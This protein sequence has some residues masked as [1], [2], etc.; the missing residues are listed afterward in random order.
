MNPTE[1]NFHPQQSFQHTLKEIAV[2]REDPCE[3]VRELISNA[4][5]AKATE[6]LVLPFLQRK[7]LIFFDNGVGLSERP[8]DL[9][10]GVVPY[11]AFF[12][13]GKTT[14]VKGSG[15]GYKCQGSKL[16][17][18]S[19]RVTIITRCAWEST[20]RFKLI[21]NPKQTLNESYD[22][23]AELV[24]EPWRILE[25]RIITEPDSRSVALLSNLS[26]SFFEEKFKSGTLIIVDGFDVQ[27]Y[28]KYF[29]VGSTDLS[30]LY[31][32]IRFLTA[33]GDARKFLDVN[34]GFTSVDANSVKSNL[35]SEPA[36]LQV[37]M[38][39]TSDAWV[40]NTVPYGYPYLPVTAE[41]E[42]T[43]TPSQV[44]RLRDGR[45]CGRYATVFDHEGQKFTLILA[46]DGKRR[47]LDEYK[48]LGRQKSA[49]CGIP[50][51]SQRG[52]FLT[53]HGVRVSSYNDI[54]REDAL[55]EFSALADNTEH[56]LL[57][58]D[59][60]FELVTN[61]NSPAPE[62]LK[63][64]KEPAFLD[65]IRSFLIDVSTKRPRGAV[66]RELV[67]RLGQERTYEREE[68]YHKLMAK[69]KESLPGRKQFQ[70]TNIA[71]LKEKWFI[72]P[73]A[74]EENMV[75]AL[76]TLFAHVVPPSSPTIS[77]W[78]RPLTFSAYGI[79]AIAS[80]NEKDLS[81]S[82]Q[83]LEY[84]HTFSVDMEF[85]HPFSITNEIVCWD[86]VESKNGTS[87]EDSYDYIA[88]IK[89][90]VK[91][92]DK[93]VGFVLGDIRLKSGLQSIG[94]EIRV[95]SLRRLLESTFTI[96]YRG[97]TAK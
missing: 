23:S 47:T 73:A 12:S 82:L 66:F 41:D 54:F 36:S 75:G 34:S 5:D 89:D 84:K 14:K 35:K 17:F 64:L 6:I 49:G 20:W 70:I 78:L 19:N 65:K 15:I 62:S 52:A 85:N 44:N 24:S 1:V 26:K 37:L 68:Q 58:M 4:Y 25:E 93:A 87:V 48:Q 16:C 92:S 39:P 38:D 91:V 60:P 69:A 88:T 7:G 77:Y 45:F 96:E 83:Y 71:D 95:I 11:V 22:L 21:D 51:S 94:H 29:S 57:F 18:A 28:G 97:A 8:E 31:N 79:D 72:E 55:A 42:K 74:G 33:H 59:G 80:T 9:K 56:H 67:E 46:I 61:R 30:Y 13:I 10:A 50:L 90:E 32:Y 76:F 63:L 86:Y 53:S 2:N 43:S 27:D 40:M 81:S 3:L